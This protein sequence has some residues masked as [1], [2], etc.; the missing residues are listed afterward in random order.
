MKRLK[1]S[2]GL[3]AFDLEGPLSPQD[4]AFEVMG[5]TERGYEL[6]ERISRYDDILTLEERPGYEPGDTLYLIVP[7]LLSEGITG[8]DILKVSQKAGLTPGAKETVEKLK[9]KGFPVVIISTSYEPHAHNIGSRLGISPEFIA[10][11]AFK[12]NLRLRTEERELILSEKKRI[13]EI[14]LNDDER[15]K[16]EL[17]EFYFK[18]LP[19]LE[20]YSYIKEIRVTG[21]RRKVEA[22][23]GFMEKFNVEPSKTVCIGDSIT[24][25]RML[26]YVNKSGGL[27]IVFNGNEYSLPYGTIAVASETLEAVILPIENFYRYGYE[28][29]KA[30]NPVPYN[31]EYALIRET[32]D[33]EALITVH[34]IMRRKIR[35]RAAQLG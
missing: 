1:G 3:I 19:H 13:L 31:A 34:K 8:E 24:D 11:T 22:L 6:F 9:D 23:I 27:A 2:S 28:G 14:S 33:M 29:L 15:L 35:G 25:F 21:G 18:K 32:E 5:L 26:D 10:C 16:K 20:I 17:D 7:F 4:N 30:L 12:A